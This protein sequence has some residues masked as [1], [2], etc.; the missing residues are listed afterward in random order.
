MC[1][2][3]TTL[4]SSHQ[5][6]HCELAMAT[7]TGNIETLPVRSDPCLLTAGEKIIKIAEKVMFQTSTQFKYEQYNTDGTIRHSLKIQEQYSCE[8][9]GIAH[10][11]LVELLKSP[12]TNNKT[13][14]DI[15]SGLTDSGEIFEGYITNVKFGDRLKYAILKKKK[16][17][18]TGQ[19]IYY[20]YRAEIDESLTNTEWPF[21]VYEIGINCASGKSC[22][23]F[24]IK[25]H[26]TSPA[27]VEFSSY[28]NCLKTFKDKSFEF[29]IHIKSTETTK[30]IF[31]NVVKTVLNH[32]Y[33]KYNTD[34]TIRNSFKIKKK[35]SC[36]I[37]VEAYDN[38]V[39]L[40]KSPITDNKTVSDI[41]SGLTGD[42]NIF[43]GYIK[44]V[45]FG[46]YLDRAI[47]EKKTEPDA[48]KYLAESDG[49]LT[50]K[51]WPFTVYEIGINYFPDT[52]KSC[53]NFVIKV[54]GTPSVP[55]KSSSYKN[56]IKTFR[57]FEFN[58]HIKSK[59]TTFA[60]VVE[61]V[62][63]NASARNFNCTSFL[64]DDETLQ[65]FT[66]DT[67]KVSSPKIFDIGNYEYTVPSENP[68]AK[69]AKK[70]SK[71]SYRRQSY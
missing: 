48:Y 19:K 46:E 26:G 37:D 5:R 61:T 49:I 27:P 34:G 68:K 2:R 50:R 13:V 29:N 57:S 16:E 51:K 15:D 67:L 28:E 23:N 42:G 31:A 36:E 22:V 8:I 65:Y 55:V 3:G 54:R 53:A 12:I 56:C 17:T 38:L 58:I 40:L 62:L 66:D 33:Q 9:H 63:T 41:D 1:N 35:Y 52:E 47:S 11:K 43:E 39:K 24:V 64:N 18:E 32:V 30:T 7:I 44:K 21:K 20:T 71:K 14:S 59:E 45:K 10:K 70:K 69:G 4:S 60:N 25:V 6:R